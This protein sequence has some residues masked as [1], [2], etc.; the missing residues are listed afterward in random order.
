MDRGGASW[1]EDTCHVWARGGPGSQKV[2]LGWRPGPGEYPAPSVAEVAGRA[3]A[4]PAG[5]ETG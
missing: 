3:A 5:G 1:L 2:A 4:P